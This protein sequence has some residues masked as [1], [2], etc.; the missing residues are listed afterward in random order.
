MHVFA[1]CSA[2]GYKDQPAIA[3]GLKA[4]GKERKDVWITTKIPPG[5]FCTAA[6][7]AAS[8]LELIQDNLHQL[9]VSYVDLTLV[10]SPCDRASGKSS[11]LD[12]KA[13]KGM[14]EAVSK[15]WTR[16]IGVDDYTAAQIEGLTN[17]GL[18]KPAVNMCSMS[19]KRHDDATIAY[20]QANG[21]TYNAFGVM[22]GCEFSH[23]TVVG[24]AKKYQTSTAQICAV[25]TR[26]R[27]CTMSLGTG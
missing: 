17:A 12:L 10:H 16:A 5:V 14:M 23:P 9:N 24:L 22:K 3:A 18:T 7:P 8:V 15:G 4:L 6:D 21:I 25:W 1:R 13:W 2:Y 19:M 11:P 26:Q 27:G 20:C